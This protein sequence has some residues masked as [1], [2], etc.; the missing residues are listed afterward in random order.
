M[1]SLTIS[2]RMSRFKDGF[3]HTAPQAIARC[4]SEL[5]V[6]GRSREGS[7]KFADFQQSERKSLRESSPCTHSA[8]IKRYASKLG[9]D[10]SSVKPVS[11]TSA[12]RLRQSAEGRLSQGLPAETA[13]R[14]FSSS[15]DGRWV[16]EISALLK[17]ASPRPGYEAS[18]PAEPIKPPI[19]SSPDI[20]FLRQD[21]AASPAASPLSTSRDY[22]LSL[23]NKLRGSEEESED[24]SESDEGDDIFER[25][26]RKIFA[27]E[28]VTSAALP[29]T[30]N[31][32]I[33]SKL[34]INV[35]VLTKVDAFVDDRKIVT[36]A[37]TC[38]TDL[39]TTDVEISTPK[40]M[41]SFVWSVSDDEDHFT[42]QSSLALSASVSAW[43]VE[44]KKQ[45]RL[46]PI[47]RPLHIESHAPSIVPG[48]TK[49]IVLNFSKSTDHLEIFPPMVTDSQTAPVEVSCQTIQNDAIDKIDVPIY[50]DSKDWKVFTAKIYDKEKSSF[51]RK[52]RGI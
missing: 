50:L 39:P 46:L 51:L 49:S 48:T 32:E 13:K 14:V 1:S 33:P 11:P 19:Q 2:E 52:C 36:N 27:E 35:G 9:I 10:L 42:I 22:F 29:E 38:T 41:D 37:A 20:S 47:I 30:T 34:E 16:A 6:V 44:K 17:Q 21:R 28:A 5:V 45:N 43:G 15:D 3:K 24:E 31:M 40:S 7:L 18:I 12:S 25:I 26:K 8:N 23:M 4:S